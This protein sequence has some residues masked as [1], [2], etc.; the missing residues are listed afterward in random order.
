M[1]TS[2]DNREYVLHNLKVPL[3]SRGQLCMIDMYLPKV[4]IHMHTF[5]HIQKQ[6][7][8]YVCTQVLL[9]IRSQICFYSP[10]QTYSLNQ[11][12]S[13]LYQILYANTYTNARLWKARQLLAK[14]QILALMINIFTH[15]CIHAYIHT[16]WHAYK[17]ILAALYIHTNIQVFTVR[18][19]RNICTGIHI[20]IHMQIH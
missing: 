16:W 8:K 7:S 12:T 15:K 20:Y 4:S 19:L 9:S 2:T 6:Q 1:S 18:F 3:F 10:V 17:E 14:I 5:I 13:I 11:F